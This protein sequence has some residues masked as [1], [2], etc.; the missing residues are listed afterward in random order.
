MTFRT[1]RR[2]SKSKLPD[3]PAM[4][5]TLSI[6]AVAFSATLMFLA[7]GY[8]FTMLLTSAI[9]IAMDRVVDRY[10]KVPQ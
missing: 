5:R 3:F 2:V 1:L 7:Q 9:A 6:M 4:A 10:D 8:R